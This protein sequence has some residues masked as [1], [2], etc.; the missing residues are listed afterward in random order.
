[1]EKYIHGRQKQ[2]WLILKTQILICRKI[3]SSLKFPDQCFTLGEIEVV[4]EAI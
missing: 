3:L 2:K 4:I 1:M